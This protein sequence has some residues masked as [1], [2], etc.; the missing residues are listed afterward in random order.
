[1][2]R[3]M[4]SGRSGIAARVLALAAALAFCTVFPASAQQITRVAVIDL[5]R[6]LAA[7][8]QDVAA[9]K[10]FETRKADVQAAVDARTA[11][12]KRLQ[13]K[14]AVAESSDDAETAKN[15]DQEIAIKTADLKEYASARQN[16]LDLLV[17]ALSSSAS[18]LKK[19]N[20]KMAQVAEA[21]GYTLVLN[22]KP[23]DQGSSIVLWNSS[24]VDITDKVIQ[25][26]N[27]DR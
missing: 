16:E 17:R 8:P 19:L 5:T 2:E 7:F 15:L 13:S 10:N 18:F 3:S 26:L 20:A 27:A 11:E 9:I 24:A 14:K 21:E 25:S 23:Q 12:I 1:M 4:A 6:V 22:S